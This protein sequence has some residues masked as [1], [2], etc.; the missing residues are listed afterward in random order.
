MG[1]A[2]AKTD[3]TIRNAVD[4][5]LFSA[6]CTNRNTRRAYGDVLDKLAGHL[7]A[8]RLLADVD[9]PISATAATSAAHQPHHQSHRPQSTAH[10]R[11]NPP[12]YAP[13]HRR[14]P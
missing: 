6:R 5:S 9:E 12:P 10:E 14:L 8:D 11:P 13:Q 3:A 1:C 2:V 7:R 4:D